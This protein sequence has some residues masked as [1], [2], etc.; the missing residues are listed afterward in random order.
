VTGG[1][2]VFT[3]PDS[4]A[5]SV[6][7]Y[8]DDPGRVRAPYRSEANAP[9]DLAGGDLAT[10][11]PYDTRALSVGTHTITAAST[12]TAGGTTTTTATMTVAR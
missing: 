7:F 5:R 6:A 10:A 9:F 4:G 12:L 3:G 8:V 2:Y 11:K 1:I